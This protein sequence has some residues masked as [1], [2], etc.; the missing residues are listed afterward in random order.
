MDQLI[1]PAQPRASATQTKA[2]SLVSEDVA[3]IEAVKQEENLLSDSAA[4]RLLIRE[5]RKYR[6]LRRQAE[7]EVLH[8]LI[9]AEI[10]KGN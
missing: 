5:G 2:F 8:R 1:S 7:Q 10:R 3:A 4:L 9:R 6:E